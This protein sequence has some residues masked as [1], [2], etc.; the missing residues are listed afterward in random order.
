MTKEVMKQDEPLAWIFEDELPKNYPY[1][2]MFPYSKVD[3]VRMFPIFGPSSKQEQEKSVYYEPAPKNSLPTFK[4]CQLIISNDNFRKRAEEGLEGRV[5]YTFRTTPIPTELHRFIYEYDDANP[6]RSAWFLHR[7]ECVLKEATKQQPNQENT[8]WEAV[9]AD[10]ALTIALLKSELDQGETIRL[11]KN[12]VNSLDNA[13]ISTWQSTCY[14]SKQ[15]DEARDYL[16]THGI[17]E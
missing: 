3:V 11:L 10:Q 17:K 15:L 8:D 2:E 12:L 7:L 14:W 1:E 16:L 5:L 9:A 6:Y 4:E 13:F